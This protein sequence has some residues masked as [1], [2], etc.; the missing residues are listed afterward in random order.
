[1]AFFCPKNR[2]HLKERLAASIR[3]ALRLLRPDRWMSIVFQHWDLTYFETILETAQA[4]GAELKA[5]ITQTG[6]VIWSMHKKKN[7]A[8]VLAGELILTFYKPKN[9]RERGPVR[10]EIRPASETIL[11]QVFDK[12]LG[13][14]YKSFTSEALFNRLVIE[15]WHRRA[16]GCLNLDRR[17]F[18]TNLAERG[19]K[20]DPKA[21]IW[22]FKENV[23][24]PA[25]MTPL[26]DE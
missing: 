21:H 20:Y 3:T 23:P 17:T 7:S 6:D 15:L 5:A 12:C 26:F 13:N 1:M 18:I 11:S 16:L 2:V 14:G 25:V 4:G 10:T 8:S 22:S 24:R 9:A 19:W